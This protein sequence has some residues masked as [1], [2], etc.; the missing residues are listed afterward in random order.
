[1]TTRPPIQSAQ[2]L[3]FPQH[4]TAGSTATTELI[5]RLLPRVRKIVFML[6]GGG[7]ESRDL[8][9]I[10]FVELLQSIGTY[11]GTGTLEAWAAGLSY[12]VVM[13]HI[14]RRR[15]RERVV[16]LRPELDI[17]RDHTGDPEQRTARQALRQRLARHMTR[18]PEERRVS[19][20]LR[21]VLG[22]SVDE[23]AAITGVGKNTA[24]DRLRVGLRELRASLAQDGE[25]DELIEESSH[26]G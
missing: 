26:D 16:A 17:E 23:V 2:V 4:E 14:S 24:R 15:R 11:K 19:L 3:P 10:C 6:A 18:L 8:V 12:R 1:M 21:V 5:E 25:I 9:N 13:R 20:V 7:D 22:H